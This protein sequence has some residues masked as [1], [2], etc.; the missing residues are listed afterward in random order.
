MLITYEI[1]SISELYGY[2]YPI[3]VTDLILNFAILILISYLISLHIYLRFNNLTTYEYIKIRKIKNTKKI[4][5]YTTSH[6]VPT[7]ANNSHR[8]IPPNS[9]VHKSCMANLQKEEEFHPFHSASQDE[10]IM[11]KSFDF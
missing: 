11:S 2:K 6:D 1:A 4:A 10:L 5:N 7:S 3:I 8:V 9:P